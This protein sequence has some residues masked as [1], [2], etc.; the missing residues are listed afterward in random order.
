LGD[1][2][3][4]I[5]LPAAMATINTT[6]MQNVPSLLA[7]SMVITM[8]RYYCAHFQMMEVPGFHKSH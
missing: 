6:T 3:L 2:S 8:R 7:V 4:R 1:Y 5:A